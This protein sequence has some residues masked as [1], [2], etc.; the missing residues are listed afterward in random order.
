[1]EKAKA[2]TAIFQTMLEFTNGTGALKT[3]QDLFTTAES[4]GDEA[5]KFYKIVR[6]L[7]YQVSRRLPVRLARRAVR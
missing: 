1:M 6:Y 7:T 2:M 3:T 4:F 5:N